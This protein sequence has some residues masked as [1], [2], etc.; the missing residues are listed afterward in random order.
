MKFL[1]ILLF[2][3]T[4]FS[5]SKCVEIRINSVKA[6]SEEEKERN[7]SL[8]YT[9][10]NLTDKTINF[11]L[12]PNAVI[13]IGAGSLNP[14]VYYK[15][16][17]NESSIDVNGIF[18]IKE[19][20]RSF[21]S[22]KE[23]QKYRDSIIDSFKNRTAETWQKEQK[24]RITNSIRQLKP[25]EELQYETVLKWDKTRYFRNDV[26]EYYINETTK[27]Y[28]ELHINLMQDEL[29][30]KFTDDEKKELLKGKNIVKGWFTSQKVEIDLSE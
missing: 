22:E 7:F 20:E 8:T 19:S 13:P 12:D 27:H 17:E 15:L 11:I 21:K 30:S 26:I 2:C 6:I 18:T 28:F 24:E 25:K 23:R 16:Y 29:L 3:S 1:Y 10:A 9:I 4:V 14:S 5:Q